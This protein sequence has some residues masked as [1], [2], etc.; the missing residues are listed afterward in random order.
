MIRA[1][2]PTCF[3]AGV[4]AANIHVSPINTVTN[5]D[6]YSHFAGDTRQR[7]AVLAYMSE[8]LVE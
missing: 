7:F 4:P 8:Y 6:Y 5:D 1:D 3:P 2:Q